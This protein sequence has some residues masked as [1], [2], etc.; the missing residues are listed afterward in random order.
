MHVSYN[1]Y[2]KSYVFLYCQQGFTFL[3]EVQLAKNVLNR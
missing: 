2:M 3:Y 1:G